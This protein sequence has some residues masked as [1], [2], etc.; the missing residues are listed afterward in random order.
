MPFI[1]LADWIAFAVFLFAWILYS[2]LF[3]RLVRRGTNHDMH[4]VRQSWMRRMAERDVRLMDANLIGH[5]IST[6]SFFA[7]T[8]LLIIAAVVGAMFGGKAT[9]E[10]MSGLSILA[11]TSL[12]L[13]DVKLALIA[14]TLARSLLDFIWGARQLNYF[15]AVLGAAPAAGDPRSVAYADAAASLL[16][17]AMSS[18]NKGVRG[19]YF[20]LAA[21]AWLF[22]PYAA[23]A[24]TIGSLW[25]LVHRQLDS[26]ASRAVGRARALLDDVRS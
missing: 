5:T 24:A 19:Y 6:A 17:P 2:P 1:S 25:L 15:L 20:A 16:D 12:Q 22:G 11:H 13:F 10:A 23:I 4:F 3:P 8:N 9:W 7:S 18:V 21:G 26:D 14:V